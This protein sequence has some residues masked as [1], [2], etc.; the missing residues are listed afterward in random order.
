MMRHIDLTGVSGTGKV[1]TGVVFENGKTVV[2]WKTFTSSINIYDSFE[3]F[4]SVHVA[5]HG[6]KANEIIWIDQ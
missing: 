6:D 4:E 3:A 5:N 1:L 2:C